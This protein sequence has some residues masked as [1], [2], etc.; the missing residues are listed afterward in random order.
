IPSYW[1]ARAAFPQ[2]GSNP[3]K[4]DLIFFDLYVQRPGA[5][6]EAGTLTD[7]CSI[8]S[9]VLADLGAGYTKDMVQCYIDCSFT[10]QGKAEHAPDSD[11][12]VANESVDFMLPYA[13]LAWAAN[14]DNCPVV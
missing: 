7:P 4:V 8:E 9:N 10:S 14:K 2:D 6:W 13:K 12:V 1:E 5:S 3:D 11:V